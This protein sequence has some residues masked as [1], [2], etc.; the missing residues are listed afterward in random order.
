MSESLIVYKANNHLE[1]SSCLSNLLITEINKSKE[2]NFSIGLSG[3]NTPKITYSLLRNDIKDF[4]RI[5]FWTVDERWVP[6]DNE[7]SNQKLVNSI[8]SDS[9]AKILEVE[10]SGI[11]ADEDAKKYSATITN[12]INTFDTVILGVGEDGHIASLFPE[13]DAIN[14]SDNIYVSNEVN[15]LSKW[16]VTATFKLLQ[17]V[18]NVYLLVTGSNKKEVLQTIMDNGDTSANKL[19][20][21]RSQTFLVTD[22]EI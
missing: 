12:N 2:D 15:V 16:R 8:F 9:G 6:Q 22:Q 21:E 10:Y 14:D 11:S 13:S 5:I 4:S 3:G 1:A 18:K 19:I 20:N 7:S 17:E